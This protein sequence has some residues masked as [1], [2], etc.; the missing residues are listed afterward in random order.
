MNH[1]L[2]PAPGPTVVNGKLL[3]SGHLPRHTVMSSLKGMRMAAKLTLGAVQKGSGVYG[4]AAIEKGK[5]INLRH[6]L[7]L[8]RFFKVPVEAIWTLPPEDAD[9]P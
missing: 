1:E 7:M 4:I 2:P 9:G 5:N 3:L 8:A 6:A